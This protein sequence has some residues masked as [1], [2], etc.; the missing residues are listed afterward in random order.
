VETPALLLCRGR[1]L[2]LT[3][4]HRTR[5]FFHRIE[6]SR[7]PGIIGCVSRTISADLRERVIA[8]SRSTTCGGRASRDI[9]PVCAGLQLRRATVPILA[10][11][12]TLAQS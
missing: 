9:E 8:A 5:A 4:P 10:R 6:L 11:S 3:F 7:I 1:T 2:R 12:S